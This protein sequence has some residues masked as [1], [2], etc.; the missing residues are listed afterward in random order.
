M[1]LVEIHILQ[2]VAPSNLNRDDTGS[3]KDAIFGGYRRLRLSS[4]AQKR[5]ARLHFR[6]LLPKENLALRTKR[7][8]DLLEE[9]LAGLGRPRE[10]AR[11]RAEIALN[12]AGLG[13][14]EGK[15]EYLLFLGERE[16]GALVERIHEAWER[17]EG[18]EAEGKKKGDK[19]LRNE[20]EGLF[21]KALDGG[22][23]V[24]LALFGRMLADKPE[25]NVDAAAQVAHALSTHKVDREFDF[26]TA[27]DDLAP[28]EEAGAGMMGDVEFAS[29]TF[30]RYAVVNLDQ[31][32]E[33]LQ[34]DRELALEGLTA[35]LR[36]FALSLP[37]GKQNSFAAHNPPKLIAIRLGQGMPRN[38][39]AAFERPIYPD[40]QGLAKASAE[41]L[42]KEWQA[43]DG[44]YGPLKGEWKALGHTLGDLEAPEGFVLA[45]SLDDLLG[46]TKEHS[47]RLLGLS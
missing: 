31:L 38:L 29:A 19:E 15:T 22:K 4:Q 33:N 25:L 47:A 44:F 27:V 21:Q 35:F 24:D 6:E 23:A 3:P 5:A 11:K 36:A 12:L 42:L 2:T 9:G 7:L 14:K 46:K 39:A 32:L 43:M 40:D 18:L 8:L 41:A 1:K 34:G 28:K 10:E 17:L 30:Y 26:Y 13:T 20:F 45:N 37:S 16:I